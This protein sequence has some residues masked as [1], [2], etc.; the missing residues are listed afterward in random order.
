MRFFQNIISVSVLISLNTYAQVH[1]SG[2]LS[3]VLEDT[4]Y[5]VDDYIRVQAEDS[6]TIE[7]GSRFLFAGNYQLQIYGAL[8]C[9]GTVEDSISFLPQGTVDFWGGIFIDENSSD[10]S[11]LS[12][13]YI[14]GSGL[15]AVN[16]YGPDIRITHCTI[17]NNFGS[18]GGGIYL[19]DSNPLILACKIINNSVGS[20][21]GGIY[22]TNSNPEITECIIAN[23]HCD[24]FGS[25][26][27]GGG[28][29]FNHTSNGSLIRCVIFDN[30]S[31]HYG[32]GIACS[33]MSD[34]EITN[35]TITGN[36]AVLAGGGINISY[37]NPNIM[38]TIVDSNFGEGGINFDIPT[39]LS[40]TYNDFNNNEG[41]DFTGDVPDTLGVIVTLNTQGDS[42]DFYYNIFMN[43]LFY[44][45][46]GDSA[47]YLTADS[48]CIDAGDPA[49]PP[50]P[51][52]TVA[53]IGAFYFN[54]E[55]ASP[56]TVS[57]TPFATPIRIPAA[58]GTF[59]FNIEIANNGTSPETIDIWT[60]ATLP[61]GSEYGP[62]IY[63]PDFNI[64][65]GWSGNR[66]R[67]QNVPASAPQG[68]Y[69]YNAYVGIY[70]DDIW[71]EDN[72]DFEKLAVSDGDDIIHGWDNCG[73]DFDFSIEES[74]ILNFEFLILN[75]FP[76]PFNASTA[77]SYQLLAVSHVNLAIYDV[78]GREI[79]SL[80]NGHLSSGMHEVIWDAKN[81]TSGVYFARLTAGEFRQVRKI[82]LVK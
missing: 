67:T 35:C 29:S 47:Y 1:I 39:G 13:C 50:D 65:P 51:D 55:P 44:S 22:A 17:E 68:F 26:L 56:I 19:S 52:S 40:I 14:S 36:S 75:C 80:V 64:A 81:L 45:T 23:N 6:L 79:Q 74:K 8:T 33:D 41:G 60:M 31:G 73:E 9:V 77:I 46:T 42:C 43:P 12:Y 16:C 24:G 3:G 66:D 62:I 72:F 82:L 11:E 76:N 18:W 48:P 7:A 38:N 20:C 53:D 69:T 61:D 5:I 2:N 4:V 70:P 59:D 32:G 49:S 78:T 37:S 30:S 57:L 58:G 54:Q 34:V 10:Y 27:G 28:I 15:G 71:D 63:F 21:G 25:G